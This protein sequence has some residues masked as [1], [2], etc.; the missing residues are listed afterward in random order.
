MTIAQLVEQLEGVKNIAA[1]YLTFSGIGEPTLASNLGPAIMIAKSILSIPVAVLTNSSFMTREDVR[2]DLA[3]AD[4]VVAKLDAPNE[5]LFRQINRPVAGYS[6]ERIIRAIRLFRQKYKG[7]LAIQMMFIKA[8]MRFVKEM[9]AIAKQLS[10]DEVQINTPLRPCAVEPL[11]PE[12]IAALRD[13]FIGCRK[14][15]TVYEASRPEVSPLNL[16]QTLRRRPK[17]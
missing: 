12:E 16:E 17:L 15:I 13:E 9:A 7:K 14:V 3:K 5:S 6:L 8:N 4:T 2:D 1:D 11:T 10:P